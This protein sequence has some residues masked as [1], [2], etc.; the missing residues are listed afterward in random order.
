MDETIRRTPWAHGF[1]RRHHNPGMTLNMMGEMGLNAGGHW[2][3]DGEGGTYEFVQLGGHTLRIHRET[4]NVWVLQAD[5]DPSK[6]RWVHIENPPPV[7]QLSV[8]F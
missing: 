2:A 3:H 1:E 6:M 4:A 5:G 7:E 8:R